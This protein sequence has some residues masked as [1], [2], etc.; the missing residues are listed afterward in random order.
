[1]IE[2]F[3]GFLSISRQIQTTSIPFQNP[4]QFI[5]NLLSCQSILCNLAVTTR[6]L[7][8][9]KG[10][11][12]RKADNL[13]AICE[14]IFQ[15]V[16]EPQ[17]LTTLWTSTA[18]YRD[19]LPFFFTFTDSIVKYGTNFHMCIV[20]QWDISLSSGNTSFSG[21]DSTVPVGSSFIEFLIIMEWLYDFDSRFRA[22]ITTG[23]GFGGGLH[24]WLDQA[25]GWLNHFSILSSGHVYLW[26][27]LS[28]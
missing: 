2:I 26:W 5:I 7:L 11:Q 14:P 17:R 27:S 24:T 1:V 9:G 19:S 13:T 21:N 18:C 10:R 16:W 12:A 4:Y 15:K 28:P 3:R 22:A 20:S 8:G 23:R 25:S 6:R